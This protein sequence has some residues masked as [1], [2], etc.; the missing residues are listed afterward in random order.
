VA[1]KSS[2]SVKKIAETSFC[3]FVWHKL[4]EDLLLPGQFT[5]DAETCQSWL[6]RVMHLISTIVLLLWDDPWAGSA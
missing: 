6:S 2:V 3:Q 1:K 4:A 5:A